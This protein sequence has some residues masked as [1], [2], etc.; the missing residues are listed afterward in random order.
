MAQQLL[1]RRGWCLSLT[2]IGLTWLLPGSSWSHAGLLKSI[3]ARQAVLMHPPE[4]VQ[5][6]FNERL[7]PQF[8]RLSVWNTHGVQVDR[9]DVQVAGDDTRQ[10]SVGLSSLPPGMY[11]VKY[12][13]LSVDG[14]VVESQFPFT[15]QARP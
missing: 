14:H 1:R 8:S 10:L 5:L 4:R 11:T 7:E 15:L 12:R 13:V 6:W 9:G 2:L 3:P